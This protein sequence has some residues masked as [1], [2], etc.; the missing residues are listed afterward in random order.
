[1]RPNLHKQ[2]KVQMTDAWLTDEPTVKLKFLFTHKES[3]TQ[4]YSTLS[5]S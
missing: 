4:I 2:P 5:L 1:M 3:H